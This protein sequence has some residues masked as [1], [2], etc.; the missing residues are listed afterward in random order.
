MCLK[1]HLARCASIA[2]VKLRLR[3][4]CC[5][6]DHIHLIQFLLA[7][8]GHISCRNTCLVSCY[9]VFQLTDLL[10]LFSVGSLQ[11]CLLNHIDFLEM[12]V[13]SYVTVQF[14]IFHVIDDIN[15]RIQER[16]IV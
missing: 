5:Q 10:L 7:G 4:L 9:E 8:H 15:Y 13:V 1:E 11:L 6:L 2:E 3:L 16:N 14:L 12:V